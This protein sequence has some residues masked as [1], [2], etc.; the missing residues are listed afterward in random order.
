MSAE[1]LA[2]PLV[3]DFMEHLEMH[4]LRELAGIVYD[5]SKCRNLLTQWE[6]EHLLDNPSPDSLAKHKQAI[7]RLVR[8]GRFLAL[9]TEQPEF[10]EPKL[11][12]IVRATQSCLQDKLALWHGKTLAPEQKA[13]IL[14]TCFD[15]S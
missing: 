12:Q 4:F 2:M 1:I 8:F 7:D 11:A 15:E 5:W 3:P 9:A 10:T 14:R 13:E 6:D